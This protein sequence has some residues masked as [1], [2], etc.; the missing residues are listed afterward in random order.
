MGIAVAFT[1]LVVAAAFKLA[2]VPYVISLK[3]SSI[4]FSVLIGFI[5]FKEKFAMERIFGTALMLLGVILITL[6]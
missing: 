1:E 4:V 5:M 3:R 2:I 6:F